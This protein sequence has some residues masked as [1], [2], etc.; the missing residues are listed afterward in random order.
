[1]AEISHILAWGDLPTDFVEHAFEQNHRGKTVPVRFRRFVST[2][3]PEEVVFVR[4]VWLLCQ[5]MQISWSKYTECARVIATSPAATVLFEVS[6]DEQRHEILAAAQQRVREISEHDRG[7]S[8]AGYREAM[9]AVAKHAEPEVLRDYLVGQTE[10][11][12]E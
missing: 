10:F 3:T 12:A 1:M 4:V 7:A 6:G 11:L 9:L 8:Y 5:L 2:M